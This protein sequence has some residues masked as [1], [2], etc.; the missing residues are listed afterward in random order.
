MTAAPP[1]TRQALVNAWIVQIVGTIVVSA[2][3][4]AFTRAGTLQLGTMGEEWRRYMFYAV[5][6]AAIPALFYVK[7]YKRLLV[8]DARLEKQGGAEHLQ[9]RTVLTKALS[10]GGALCELPMAV[11]VLQMLYGGETRIFLGATFITLALR[12]SYRPFL[13]KT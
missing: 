13:K 1:K 2:A 11:G 10:V 4:Y 9:A 7:H 12:L 8:Q 3:V 6:G 5:L